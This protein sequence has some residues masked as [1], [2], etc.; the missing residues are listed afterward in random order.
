MNA[1][2]LLVALLVL[3]LGCGGVT[4]IHAPAADAI[5]LAQSKDDHTPAEYVSRNKAMNVAIFFDGTGN[6]LN[7]TTNV[8]RLH[9]L[10]LNQDRKDIAVFYTSGV[11]A[12]RTGPLGLATG[13][14]FRKDV[15]A[16][17]GFLSDHYQRHDDILHLYGYSR[18][19][20]SARALAGL[21]H[22]VGLVDLSATAVRKRV[23]REKFLSDLFSA[24][25]FPG[26]TAKSPR[27]M[28][29]VDEPQESI[30][31]RRCATKEVL[32]TYGVKVKQDANKQEFSFDRV[33]FAVVGL[34]DTVETLG[35]P[36]GRQEPDEYNHRYSD[37]ICNM[38]KV[39]HAVS[40]HGNRATA[41]TPILMTRNRLVRDCNG[42][43][44]P[45]IRKAH[46]ERVEEVWF[47]G[48]HGQVGGTE[49]RGYLAGVSLNWMLGSAAN[50]GVG[51]RPL[52]PK[53]ASVHEQPLDFVKDGQGQSALFKLFQRQL[54][55]IGL[56]VQ[57]NTDR[58]LQK[59]SGQP[60]VI[61]F[62]YSVKQRQDAP[63]V[64]SAK[65][66]PSYDGKI[67]AGLGRD[68]L[69]AQIAATKTP[70]G[71]GA[72]PAIKISYVK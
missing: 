29:R 51:T 5:L 19:A 39:F 41:Y 1:K 30:D 71:L 18:G 54:R 15:E 45:K 25:K 72:C 20:F 68:E 21:V 9:Q 50:T 13:L 66:R 42:A 62:H 69:K 64:I 46:F 55:T 27:C 47:A 4:K 3:L 57:P 58:L 59:G 43:S 28:V 34:W 23:D 33:R 10:V 44:D 48:D 63:K 60:C 16:A 24:Y 2:F 11:G 35:L 52:F 26:K 65:Q 37:Q 22:T 40:L 67:I 49:D 31:L 61:K 53:G 8:G 12:D 36:N 32:K 38:D 7:S 17:Y 6:S 70:E 14:G 56:Y